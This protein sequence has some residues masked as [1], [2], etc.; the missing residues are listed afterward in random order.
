MTK[1]WHFGKI[2]SRVMVCPSTKPLPYVAYYH[3]LHLLLCTQHD[4]YPLALV[5]LYEKPRD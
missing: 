2:I 1:K 4:Y 5:T 3:E